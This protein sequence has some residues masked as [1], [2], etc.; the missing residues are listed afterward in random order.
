M[1]VLPLQFMPG[2]SRATLGLNGREVFSIDGIAED[3]AP[4]KVLTVSA[5]RGDGSEFSFQV[6]CRI[7]TPIEI[8]YYRHGGILPYV[9]RLLMKSGA[10]ATTV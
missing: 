8:E 7:D 10:P 3:L 1:G 9:L 2:Q 6:R 5:R 4:G